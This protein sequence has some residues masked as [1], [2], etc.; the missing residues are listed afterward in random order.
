[1]S[2]WIQGVLIGVVATLAMDAWAIVARRVLHWPTGDWAHVGR[3]FGH[4]ARGRFVHRPIGASAPVRGEL[5]IGWTAHYAIG[6]AYGLAYLL[7]ARWV[8]VPPESMLWA[9]VF[10]LLLLVFPWLVMQPAL[11]AGAF[12]SRAPNPALRRLVSVSMHSAFG[13]GLCIGARLIAQTPA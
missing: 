5:A 3:W 2:G 12:S 13:V 11:G 1:M 8:A 4:M 9:L 6:I 10:A 7:F